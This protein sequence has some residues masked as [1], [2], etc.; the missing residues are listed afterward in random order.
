MRELTKSILSFSWAI[1]LFGLKQLVN[2]ALPQDASR[3]WGKAEDAFDAVT[4]AAQRQL[5]GVWA[6]T[7]KTGDQLQRQA[8]DL[9]FGAFSGDIWNPNRWLQLTSDVMQGGVGAVRQAAGGC[10]CGKTGSDGR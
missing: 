9:A 1:P 7:W 3:P 10:G 5:D 8:V 6:S 2:I 4:G